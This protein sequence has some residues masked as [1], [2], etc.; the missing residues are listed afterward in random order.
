MKYYFLQN[1]INM[2]YFISDFSL[3]VPYPLNI[4]SS[5]EVMCNTEFKLSISGRN[6]NHFI[7]TVVMSSGFVFVLLMQISIK[8][9]CLYTYLCV[10]FSITFK[11]GNFKI[12]YFV[13]S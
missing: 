2:N 4:L 1:I 10:C 3:F 13:L 6:Y 5:Y 8:A 9:K 12:K 7:L 11:T